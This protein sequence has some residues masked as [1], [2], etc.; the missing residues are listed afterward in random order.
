M[1][2]SYAWC[3]GNTPLVQDLDADGRLEVVR[4]AAQYNAQ[5]QTVG[6]G[7]LYVWKLSS[8]PPITAW[9]MFRQNAE[10]RA[11]YQPGKP[12]DSRVVSHAMPD[13]LSS[14]GSTRL[15]I[16]LQNTG[17][18][19][20][21]A[22]SGIHLKATADNTIAPGKRV[23][24]GAGEAIA[25]GQQKT[26]DFQ[27]EGGGRSGYFMNSW[28]LAD[29]SGRLQGSSVWQSAKIG[30]EPAYYVLSRI[31]SGDSGGVWAGG[32]ATRL[33]PP[34]GYWNWQQARDLVLTSDR[35]GYELLDYQGGVWQ[36]GT[37]PAPGGHGFVSD[38]VELL[39]TNQQTTSYYILN[40]YARL[41]GS[42]GTLAISPAPPVQAAPTARSGVLTKDGRGVYVLLGNGIILPGGNAPGLPGSP[43]FGIDIAKKI[44][45]APQGPGAYVLD[46]YGRVWP[47]A[48]APNISPNYALHLNEDWARDLV[49][50]EDGRGFYVL[51]KEGRIHTGGSAPRPVA[52]LTPTWAGQDVAVALAVADSRAASTLTAAPTEVSVVLAPAQSQTVSFAVNGCQAGIPWI[53]ESNVAWAKVQ[54]P[55]GQ[56][57]GNL[58]VA[59]QPGNMAPGTHT[60]TLTVKTTDGIVHATTRIQ[61]RVISNLYKTRVPLIMR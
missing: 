38:A 47:F 57:P 20:W 58:S 22:A 48:G 2:V 24:F 44:Q 11:I 56:T 16:T 53:V 39:M 59:V 33:S 54:T 49:I 18:Q 61:L 25:P 9:P 45:L 28:R 27:V 29:A 7:L 4:A 51:D 17:T 42:A 10:H 37:A 3:Q 6:N 55:T 1:Y 15:Q 8:A 21:T 50:T 26:F 32:L 52:N 36:G 60:G 12:V 46:A 31:P 13:V 35:Q 41:T 43:Y 40:R 34:A 19:A 5:S 14:N 30:C 23:D